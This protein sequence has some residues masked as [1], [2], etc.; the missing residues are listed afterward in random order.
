MISVRA[1]AFSA[2][3]TVVLG[4]RALG[5]V[6][7]NIAVWAAG[8]TAAEMLPTTWQGAAGVTIANPQVTAVAPNALTIAGVADDHRGWVLRLR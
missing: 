4:E 3:G 2:D 8:A 7:S 1:R 5:G 6:L